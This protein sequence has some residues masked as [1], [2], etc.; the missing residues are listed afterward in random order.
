MPDGSR[1]VPEVQI[2]D[3]AGNTFTL[4]ITGARGKESLEYG[5]LAAEQAGR[6]YRTVRIRADRE[7]HLESVWWTG[8]VIKNMP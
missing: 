1:V 4:K 8:V 3:G 5:L 6:R 2:M 7:I